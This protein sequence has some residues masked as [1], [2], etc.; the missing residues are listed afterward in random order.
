M[1]TS[2]IQQKT[3]P[4]KKKV[5]S[6]NRTRVI[7]VIKDKV[8]IKT[9]W[10]SSRHLCFKHRAIGIDRAAFYNYVLPCAERI[11]CLDRDKGIVYTISVSD[12]QS[13]AVG[14]DLGWGPQLFCPLKYWQKTDSAQMSFGELLCT[15]ER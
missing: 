2:I 11:E 6:D 13:H 15:Q 4:I 14:D 5:F 9:N 1:I 8:F 12:F 10:H 7:G 3:Q